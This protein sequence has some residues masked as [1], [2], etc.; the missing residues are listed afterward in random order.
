MLSSRSAGV[1]LCCR[2]PQALALLSYVSTLKTL[3]AAFAQRCSAMP[4]LGVAAHLQ[5][6]QQAWMTRRYGSMFTGANWWSCRAR[7]GPFTRAQCLTLTHLPTAFHYS[8]G[9]SFDFLANVRMGPRCVWCQPPTFTIIV[10]SPARGSTIND[11]PFIRPALSFVATF[12]TNADPW[13]FAIVGV[14]GSCTHR[15]QVVLAL[16]FST[17]LFLWCA[18]QTWMSPNLRRLMCRL[19]RSSNEQVQQALQKSTGKQRTF[20]GPMQQH[21]PYPKIADF[22]QWA[23]IQCVQCYC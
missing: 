18:H 23:H 5:E 2:T 12:R 10:V 11:P 22:V 21:G 1:V 20:R 4:N 16:L 7:D 17:F 19:K 6:I 14:S 15:D 9:L 3:S 8:V 13:F